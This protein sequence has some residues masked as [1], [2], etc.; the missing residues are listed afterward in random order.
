MFKRHRPDPLPLLESA[1]TRASVFTRL[2]WRQGL[3]N[4]DSDEPG[5]TQQRG[6]GREGTQSL[7]AV[8]V[9][10]VGGQPVSGSV[11]YLPGPAVFP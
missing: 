5:I 10:G 6:A 1:G 8:R 7:E 2:G 11:L 3:G 4:T 9:A